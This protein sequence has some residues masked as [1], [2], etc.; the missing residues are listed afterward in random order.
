MKDKKSKCKK[1]S[2]DLKISKKKKSLTEYTKS[3]KLLVKITLIPIKYKKSL[4]KILT[5]KNLT[6]I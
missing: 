1:K 6:K 3:N 5:L 4:M 2:K